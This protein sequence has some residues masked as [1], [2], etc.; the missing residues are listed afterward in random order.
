MRWQYLLEDMAPWTRTMDRV[1]ESRK[2]RRMRP[3]RLSARTRV[4]SGFG[5][6]HLSPSASAALSITP[7]QPPSMLHEVL[8]NGTGSLAHALAPCSSV[9]L[10]RN[11][12]LTLHRFTSALSVSISRTA[13]SSP[14]AASPRQRSPV[15]TLGSCTRWFRARIVGIAAPR[16]GVQTGPAVRT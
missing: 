6:R 7:S 8:L 11:A 3:V 12:P 16:A 5:I 14:P 4:P 9:P 13:P 10:C 1:K 15:L 2:L